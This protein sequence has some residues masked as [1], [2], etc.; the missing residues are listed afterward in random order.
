MRN[1]CR[2]ARTPAVSVLLVVVAASPVRAGDLP[3]ITQQPQGQAVCAGS[4]VTFTVVATGEDLSYQWR[5]DDEGIPGATLDTLSLD[6]VTVVDA[7]DYDVIVVNGGGTV[8]SDPATLVVD[9]GPEII[10]QPQAEAVCESAAFALSV[11]VANQGTTTTDMIGSAGNS[12][13]STSGRTRGNYYRVD[14][15]TTL[16][17]I[18]HYMNVT[19]SGTITFFVYEADTLAGPYALVAQDAV[20]DCGTGARYFSSSALAVSLEAGK[21]YIIGATWPG[22]HTYYWNNTQP[23]AVSFGSSLHGYSYIYL[24]PLPETP[25]TPTNGYAYMQ[26]LTTSDLAMTYQWRKD[27]GA[28]PGAGGPSYTISE[29]SAADVGDYDVVIT[30]D[31]GS[32]I[33]DTATLTLASGVTITDDPNDQGACVGAPAIF[34]VQV[35]GPDPAYQWRK[36]GEE[37]EGETLPALFFEA[38]TL[39]D[40]G[41]YDVV[42]SNDCGSVTS[43]TVTL[44]V[45]EDVPTITEQPVGE[46]ACAGAAVTFG[47]IAEGTGLEYQWRKDDEEIED[48]KSATYEIADADPNDA[49]TY[50]VVVSTPCGEVAS[51]AVVLTVHEPISID[52]QPVGDVICAAEDLVLT[53]VIGGTGLDLQWRKDGEDI[54]DATGDTYV[55]AGA[56]LADT[57]GYELVI[58]NNC[59]EVVSD[60]AAVTVVEGPVISTQPR[61]ARLA[62]GD[63]LELSVEVDL[64]GFPADEDAVGSD[65]LTY[66]G[67]NK[68]RGNAYEVTETTTLTL[69]EHYLDIAVSGSLFFYVYEAEAAEGP[70]T[71]VYDDTVSNTGTGQGFVASNPLELLLEAGKFYLI[72]AGWTSSYTYYSGGGHPCDTAFGQSV[73]GFAT[74]Y[75]GSLPANPTPTSSNVYYQ[76]LT[77]MDPVVD[78]QWRLDGEDIVDAIEP[79]YAIENVGTDDAG[80]YDVVLTNA[81]GSVISEPA[82]VWVVYSRPAPHGVS[83]LSQPVRDIETQEPPP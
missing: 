12:G 53:A 54:P 16:T 7:G 77:T 46:D 15:A 66:S 27:D 29:M 25:A 69:I 60:A 65:T 5:K 67:A 42:V 59:G 62:T 41:E 81:C 75:L 82:S 71:L 63:P 55:I 47:V 3:V 6:A 8:T 83:S 72:G 33:S 45:G 10:E 30:S 24:D 79:R 9:T 31:C 1:L 43:E 34:T 23:H 35:D 70:Y 58:T 32:T 52:E 28:I 50:D 61:G 18:E 73:S 68:L 20:T 56:T 26:R 22:N 57:G 51:D 37:I 80:V 4:D 76:R 48:A 13:S 74:S 38:V 40:A 17:R 36:A 11:T 44:T 14:T 19:V 49:G 21:Y 64:A 39:E 78:Y 2:L